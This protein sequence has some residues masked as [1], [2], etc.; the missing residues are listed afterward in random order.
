MWPQGESY[1]NKL[2]ETHKGPDG[3]MTVAIHNPSNLSVIL[4][5]CPR[6]DQ[7]SVHLFER[8]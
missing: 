6:A 1:P 7:I 2:E 4:G 3:R 8:W 5:F